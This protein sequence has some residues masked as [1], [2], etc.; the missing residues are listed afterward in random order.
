MIAHKLCHLMVKERQSCVVFCL[1]LCCNLDALFRE[2]MSLGTFNDT[3]LLY[4]FAGVV[5]MLDWVRWRGDQVTMACRTCVLWRRAWQSGCK[6]KT[7][8]MLR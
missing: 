8:S 6:V 2:L 4:T 7:S 1:K 3:L 5:S